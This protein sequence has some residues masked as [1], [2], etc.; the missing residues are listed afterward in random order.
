MKSNRKVVALV[1]VAAQIAAVTALSGCRKE[2][3]GIVINKEQTQLYVS[4]YTGGYGAQ[5]LEKA[6][7][8]F[9]DAFADKK[10]EAEKT[11]VQIVPIQGKENGTELFS[12]IKGNKADVF[13]TE[14]VYMKDFVDAGYVEEITD[15]VT[16]K[17]T[18]YG[19]SKSIEDKL[20][21]EQKEYYGMKKPDGSTAYYMIPHYQSFRG[22][23][24][25]RD[26]FNEE[27]FFIAKN[28]APSE[29]LQEGGAFSGTYSFT[30]ESSPRSAGP[31]GKY[32]TSD[33]GLPATYEEFY[34]LCARIKKK[35]MT[36][37][38]YA[39]SVQDYY[40]DFM[41]A[42]EIN[43]IG[44]EAGAAKYSLKG[45]LDCIVDLE[46]LDANGSF[47]LKETVK[48]ENANGYEM[49]ANEGKL[50]ALTFTEN[51]IKGN[52]DGSF[53]SSNCFDSTGHI[54]TQKY[55]LYGRYG[56]EQ[57]IAMIIEGSF[58]ENEADPTFKLMEKKNGS[59]AGRYAR[60][61]AYMPYPHSTEKK[62]GDDITLVDSL[63]SV[64]F[65]K[66]GLTE[67]KKALA[68]AYLQFLNTDVSLREFNVTTGAPKSLDYE[69]TDEDKGQLSYFGKSIIEL[70]N[71]K[72]SNII[73]PISSNP[74]YLSNPAFF[75]SA[76]E[77]NCI[78]NNI[79]Y[80]SP[81]KIMKEKG[82]SA[83]E[84]FKGISNRVTESMWENS[85]GKFYK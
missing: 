3:G 58:W 47:S 80:E 46:T 61:F 40:N 70:K 36:P 56:G 60:R 44:R 66:S 19:E 57:Q 26:L 24:Y 25:D 74:I 33:D 6:N 14:G 9:Q 35:G 10:F 67:E 2:D 28:G 72:N 16:E 83:V 71:Q 49:F 4:S 63:L 31:D 52:S 50:N 68:K 76:N 85:F 73:F 13:L 34:A 48:I 17:M 21:K 37:V 84:I 42:M 12:K 43:D 45:E 77:W 8:R 78:V 69:L 23:I 22:L 18:E 53:F 20:T 65:I 15:I 64:G 54:E 32:K 7:K 29:R 1:L 55:F 82:Y 81:Q 75:F 38:S 5:W 62:I 51:L 39:G 11:G 41:T 30:N 59:E 27:K 79:P